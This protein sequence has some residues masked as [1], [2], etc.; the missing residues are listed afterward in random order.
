[1]SKFTVVR[2]WAEEKGY[3]IEDTFAY[4]DN[5]AIKVII[6]DE[7]SFKC[8]TKKSTIYTSIRG[9]KG[10]C[11]GLYLTHEHKPKDGRFVRPYDF[12]KTSQKEM[13]QSME[14]EIKNIK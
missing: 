3:K 6:N 7:H 12:H 8:E 10:N 4:G 1:M 14:R 5:K 11:G 9:Q 2:K 13:I